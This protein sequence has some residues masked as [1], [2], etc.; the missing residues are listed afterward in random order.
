MAIA[1]GILAAVNVIGGEDLKD[2]YTVP[3]KKFSLVTISISNR[4]DAST[5]IRLALI[6]AKTA[7]EVTDKDYVIYDL[8]TSSLVSN[9]APIERTDVYLGSND[10]VA[11]YSSD[12]D[13]TVQVNGVEKDNSDTRV[14]S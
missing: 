12:E 2:I 3:G 9:L 11:V 14:S 8:P 1:R 4:T 5:N 10:T 6:K 13:V 7:S